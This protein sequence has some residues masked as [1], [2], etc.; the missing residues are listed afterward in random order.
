[1][2]YMDMEPGKNLLQEERVEVTSEIVEKVV[3]KAIFTW[4]SRFGSC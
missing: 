4:L 3:K 1:M 2:F